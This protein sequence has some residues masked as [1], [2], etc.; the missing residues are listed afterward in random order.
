MMEK[1][2]CQYIPTARMKWWH[3][4]NG[5]ALCIQNQGQSSID[6]IPEQHFVCINYVL[7]YLIHMVVHVIILFLSFQ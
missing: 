3:T 5:A 7:I 2:C 1:R 6:A 4:I